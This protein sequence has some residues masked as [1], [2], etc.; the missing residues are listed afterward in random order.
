MNGLIRYNQKG[1]FNSAFHY[2]RPGI[3]PSKLKDNLKRWSELLNKNNVEFVCRDFREVMAQP[4]DYLY[5]DPPYANTDA[6]YYGK[7]N[8]IDF[9]DWLSKQQCSYSISFDGIS[10]EKDNTYE[11]PKNIY[12]KHIYLSK[13]ISGF[14]KLQMKQEYVQE[15]LYIKTV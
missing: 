2:G 12:D 4:N 3:N 8:Y 6:M 1:E 13:G 5:V 7:I 15:S 11:V 9:W 14:K 10:G